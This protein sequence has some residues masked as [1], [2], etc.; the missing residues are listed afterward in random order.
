MP[1]CVFR[2]IVHLHVLNDMKGYK[3]NGLFTYTETDSGVVILTDPPFLGSSDHFNCCE[4]DPFV[5]NINFFW[6]LTIL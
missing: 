5:I 6:Q 2:V 3:T 1:L 4:W